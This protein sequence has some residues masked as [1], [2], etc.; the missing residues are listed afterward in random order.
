MV[1]LL[2]ILDVTGLKHHLLP[3]YFYSTLSFFLS[4]LSF[5][6][7]LVNKSLSSSLISH[8]SSHP[9]VASMLFTIILALLLS[10]A[11]YALKIYTQFARNLAAARKSGIP[12]I[13]IPF[14]QVNRLYMLSQIVVE[15]IVRKLPS[16]WTEP[17]FDLT[18]EWAWRLKYEPFKR[19]GTDTFL[20]VSPERNE[21]YT[22]DAD[23]I[24]QIT[25]RKNDFPKPLEMYES[26]KIYGNNVVA[27]EGQL[28]RHHRKI[29]GPPFSERNNHL[30]WTETL[31][32]C[33]A[34]VNGWFDGNT[35][36][37]GTKTIHTLADDA[38][39]LSLYIISRA[40]FG[41]RLKW[42]GAEGSQANG[43]VKEEEKGTAS[44]S[45]FDRGH[46]LSYTDALGLLLHNILWIFL[47]P[48]FL[49]S[50]SMTFHIFQASANSLKSICRSKK[51]KNRTWLSLNGV[52]I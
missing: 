47:L 26:L 50:N 10:L 44:S 38:M 41:V 43:H 16:S 33:Q 15:P 29:T 20:T 36:K 48:S 32:Q 8:L 9:A 18:L 21:L 45:D 17:W 13:I 49:L 39:R 46:M 28:W 51:Q 34:M 40:G 14:Y 6:P 35:Q 2:G 25:T 23:V 4:F 52:S 22:A 42:P 5:L 12:Y 11:F 27:S 24:S 31:E 19:F 30:V 1:R 3:P 7:F 37:I